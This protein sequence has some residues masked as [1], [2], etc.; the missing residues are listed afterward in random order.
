MPTQELQ[1]FTKETQKL[2]LK[3]LCEF[4]IL[5][6][7]ELS[8]LLQNRGKKISRDEI[9]QILHSIAP[10]KNWFRASQ[11]ELQKEVLDYIWNLESQIL[12]LF[13]P[14]QKETTIAE[15][16][17]LRLQSK[18][19]KVSKDL[20]KHLQM[21]LSV[22]SK[23]LS[24]FRKFSKELTYLSDIDPNTQISWLFRVL[25]SRINLSSISTTEDLCEKLVN[26]AKERFSLLCDKAGKTT[27]RLCERF[28][29]KYFPKNIS[30]SL[31]TELLTKYQ[32]VYHK[33]ESN[34]ELERSTS[35]EMSDQ[36]K[37]FQNIIDE[38]IKTQD[39]VR[40]SSEGG[41]IGKLLNGKIKSAAVIND[42]LD[43]IKNLI[44][45]L[46][47]LFTN[48]SKSG[49]E[50]IL[51]VQKLQTDYENVLV[52]KSQ[53]ENDLYTLR[54]TYKNLEEKYSAAQNDLHDKAESLEKAHEKVAV[55][56][57]R[58]EEVPDLENKINLL[59]D[60]VFTAKDL[61]VRSY[62]RLVRLKTD[63]LNGQGLH[64][65]KNGSKDVNQVEM[66]SEI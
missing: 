18:Q 32:S 6:L 42:K 40:N 31:L 10:N 39:L 26:E 56:Q 13:P 14:K 38:I 2:V 8:L 3:T 53:L 66:G 54:D 50:K 28:I 24:K 59:R 63:L 27:N 57:Q 65:Q 33:Y 7:E 12:F 48:V 4:P 37:I 46:Q 11:E 30:S 58:V 64:K 21:I 47:E 45:Q 16:N 22:E 15:F 43:K 60:D 35:A 41:F 17:Q 55:L 44:S 5:N 52:V 20:I 25:L 51:V 62:A 19:S 36:S 61:A 23:N 34:Q 9:I 29:E 49:S 1:S